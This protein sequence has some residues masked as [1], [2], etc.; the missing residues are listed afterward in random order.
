M[1][2]KALFVFVIAVLP[3]ACAHTFELGADFRLGN[4]AFA[5][6]RKIG[7]L[8]MPGS[9][10]DWGISVFAGQ[11]ISDALRIDVGFY[12]DPILQNISYTTISYVEG[13]MNISVGPFFGFFNSDLDPILK[14]GI[15]AT[16]KL[17]F[18]GVFFIGITADSTLNT[19]LGT[20]LDY[21]QERTSVNGGFYVPNA[22]CTFAM[23]QKKFTQLVSDKQVD[24][25]MLE[26][27][28]MSD[29]YKKNTPYRVDIGFAYQLLTKSFLEGG[30][31]TR[32][33]L[34]SMLVRTALIISI[35]DAVFLTVG[36]DTSVYT[37]GYDELLAQKAPFFAFNC[38][39]G[40]KINFDRFFQLGE[41]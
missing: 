4:L 40:I 26:F 38:H 20:D 19:R 22:I 12:S 15:S 1:N 7:D 6:D 14:P 2:K 11:K 17:D 36:A 13:I 32:Y 37:Y 34:G 39:A 28:F 41:L 30:T 10:F 18:P 9:Y 25:S 31:T 33:T 16:V 23:N 5:H 8:S 21:I 3:L 27:L 35:T 24:D 29:I